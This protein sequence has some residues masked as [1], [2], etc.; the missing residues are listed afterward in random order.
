MDEVRL[1]QQQIDPLSAN[2]EAAESRMIRIREWLE[3]LQKQRMTTQTWQKVCSAAE[4]HTDGTGRVAA[5]G[6]QAVSSRGLTLVS[7]TELVRL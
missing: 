4:E 7:T 2:G 5:R 6:Y 1:R 3:R